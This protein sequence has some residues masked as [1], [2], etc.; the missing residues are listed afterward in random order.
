MSEFA[1]EE[2]FAADDELETPVEPESSVDD[3][4]S[5]AAASDEDWED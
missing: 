2:T 5:D 1:S 4:P 3:G